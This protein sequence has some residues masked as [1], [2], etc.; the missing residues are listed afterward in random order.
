MWPF[1]K[2]HKD[3]IACQNIITDYLLILPASGDWDDYEIQNILESKGHD[4]RLSWY[5]I[6]LIPSFVAREYLK[7]QGISSWPNYFCMADGER[8]IR[9]PKQIQFDDFPACRAI[10]Q[11]Q[12]RILA[13]PNHMRIIE[14]SAE[15]NVVAKALKN[16][17]KTENL[18]FTGVLLI[19][20]SWM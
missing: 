10:M 5:V 7:Q 19:K 13:H 8:S 4:K 12:Q 20:P 2:K 1:N 11:S 17:S 18:R 15:F 9:N 14:S 16:G 3:E 6:S